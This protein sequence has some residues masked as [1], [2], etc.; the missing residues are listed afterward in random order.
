MTE[1]DK[2][3]E[4]AKRDDVDWLREAFDRAISGDNGTAPDTNR[5]ALD[6]FAGLTPAGETVPN[7][8]N[9]PVVPPAV[10]PP[11]P[12]APASESAHRHDLDLDF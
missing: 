1:N 4:N 5:P 12:T 2:D 11:A 10:V 9:V 6:P 7:D 8:P 3:N